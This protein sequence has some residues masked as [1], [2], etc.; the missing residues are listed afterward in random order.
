MPYNDKKDSADN[1]QNLPFLKW[2]WENYQ[3]KKILILANLIFFLSP[4]FLY[5]FE[6]GVIIEDSQISIRSEYRRLFQGEVVKITMRS[7]KLSSSTA[8][9]NGKDYRFVP[10]GDPFTSFFL[11]SLGLD[12]KPGIHDLDIRIEFTDGRKRDFSFK[13]PVSKG[14]FNLKRI[15]VDPRFISPPPEARERIL[16][17]V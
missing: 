10:T 4:G 2:S 15:K 7:P 9:F 12:I 13:I 14:K 3:M 16:K 17:E 8:H 1:P 6:S 5:P 11:M